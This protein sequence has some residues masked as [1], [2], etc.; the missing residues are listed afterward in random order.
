MES[1]SDGLIFL[2][3]GDCKYSKIDALRRIYLCLEKVKSEDIPF[4]VIVAKQDQDGRDEHVSDL[5]E[6]LRLT[7]TTKVPWSKYDNVSSKREFIN[8]YLG[9][10]MTAFQVRG[11]L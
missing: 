8:M 10:S 2:V 5:A 9:V 1:D 3:D 4:L 7:D 11:N 6:A